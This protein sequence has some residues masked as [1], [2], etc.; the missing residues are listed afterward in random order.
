LFLQELSFY[1]KKGIPMQTF[2]CP[3]CGH[4]SIFDPWIESARCTRCNYSPPPL[5]TLSRDNADQSDFKFQ[6]AREEISQIY[7]TTKRRA[8]ARSFIVLVRR[9]DHL[10]TFGQDAKKMIKVL[11]RGV[12]AEELFDGVPSPTVQIPFENREV[13]IKRV[14]AA[15]YEIGLA[16]YGVL[17]CPQCGCLNLTKDVFFPSYECQECDYIPPERNQLISEYLTSGTQAVNE[18]N[19]REAYFFLNQALAHGGTAYQQAE[20]LFWLA[21]TTPNLYEKREYLKKA[22]ELNPAEESISGSIQSTLAQVDSILTGESIPSDTPKQVT[23]SPDNKPVRTTRHSCPRCGGKMSYVPAED[24]L[25]C[26]SCHHSHAPR[27]EDDSPQEQSFTGAMASLKGHKRPVNTRSL[28]C[29]ACG[30]VFILAPATLSQA[31]PY[32]TTAYTLEGETSKALIPPTGIIPFS[33]LQDDAQILLKKWFEEKD[34][35]APKGIK[36]LLGIYLPLWTF[37]LVGTLSW[38]KPGLLFTQTQTTS[39]FFDDILVP[40][41]SKLPLKLTQDNSDFGL[42][43]LAPY[44]SDYLVDWPAET[45]DISLSD[46]AIK[47]RGK[48]IDSFRTTHRLGEKAQIHTSRLQVDSFKLVLAPMWIT[49]FNQSSN[50]YRVIVHG[51][52]G[53]VRVLLITNR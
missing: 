17:T 37:D 21:E 25:V 14:A 29:S 4:K 22:L 52:S 45:Y 5:G 27:R 19:L 12:E 53:I 11:G 36:S 38:T 13:L 9:D 46:A 51:D 1:D 41:V 49:H 39:V 10:F 23:E 48:A 32:C 6:I 24:Q 8:P 15:G 47:S 33:L 40:A 28:A 35:P 43:D 7:K 44:S 26:S 34:L 2:I 42:S 50:R 3:Q 18:G 30:A 20:A 16:Q 31:C